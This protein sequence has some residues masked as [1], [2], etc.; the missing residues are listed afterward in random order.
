MK[1]TCFLLLLRY[2]LS[3]VYLLT[4]SFFGEG[5][6][7]R[8][9]YKSFLPGLGYRR[10]S[11]NPAPPP[12]HLAHNPRTSYVLPQDGDFP[13]KVEWRGERVRL[14]LG[15]SEGRTPSS[16]PTW[17]GLRSTMGFH[18]E[19]DDRVGREGHVSYR[20]SSRSVCPTVPRNV[21]VHSY[22]NSGRVV[23]VCLFVCC[24]CVCDVPPLSCLFL[25][26]LGC[27]RSSSFSLL[28][29]CGNNYYVLI[30]YFILFS[31]LISSLF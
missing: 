6:Y 29:G 19:D 3:S 18:S 10:P 11:L 21:S 27:F 24:V 7:A 28:K 4:S 22:V 16:V 12:R 17:T 15:I 23:C 8:S 26:W 20:V 9:F 5:L 13:V 14:T 31:E 2:F 25:F 30:F 1:D